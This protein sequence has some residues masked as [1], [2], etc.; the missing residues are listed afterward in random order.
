[1]SESTQELDALVHREYQE[2][3]VTDIESDTLPPGL[4][5][6][7]IREISRRK[8]EPEFMLEWRLEAYRKWLD[9]P[10]PNW[11]HINYS[12]SIFRIFPISLRLKILTMGRKA[13]MR[14]IPGCWKPMPNWA[15][16]WT[17]K[18]FSRV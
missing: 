15:F 6:D 14:L 10:E 17:S 8:N 3:F 1:M 2:G 12:K 18:R 5:E 16:R 13:S 11:A 7:V 9:M 4:N